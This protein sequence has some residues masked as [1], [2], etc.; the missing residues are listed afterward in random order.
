MNEQKQGEK[1][2]GQ[3]IKPVT[4]LKNKLRQRCFPVIIANTNN[5]LSLPVSL[6]ALQKKSLILPH[7]PCAE[8]SRS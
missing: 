5:E 6:L 3:K 2:Q 4:L 7:N 8:T 1:C